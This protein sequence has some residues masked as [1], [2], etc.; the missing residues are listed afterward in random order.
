MNR[1]TL[2]NKQGK[3]GA[4]PCRA[5]EVAALEREAYA[6]CPLG[7]GG[8]AEPPP[9][10]GANL[11]PPRDEGGGLAA[12]PMVPVD[13]EGGRELAN[14][15]PFKSAWT[16]RPDEVYCTPQGHGGGLR[17]ERGNP[18]GGPRRGP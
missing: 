18:R 5:A 12:G 4:G 14:R 8:W 9:Y 13:L 2:K 1:G 16:M 11:P 6:D 7:S 15:P 10:L 3:K 17:A